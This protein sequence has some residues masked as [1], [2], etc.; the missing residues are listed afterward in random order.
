VS[1]TSAPRGPRK[2]HCVR[3]HPRTKPNLYPNN[4]C[5]LCLLQRGREDRQRPEFQ[6]KR[7]ARRMANI[8][9]ERAKQRE[10]YHAHK[11]TKAQWAREYRARHPELT[12]K[13]CLRRFR[14]TPEEFEKILNAQG[15]ACAICRTTTPSGKYRQWCVDHDHRCCPGRKKS[16][17]KCIRGLLCA[18]CNHALGEAKDNPAILREMANYIERALEQRLGQKV[19]A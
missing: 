14:M 11:A 13:I 7:R 19:A 12:R 2:T 10:S 4:T 18:S 9:V 16:C 6:Q 1:G 8:E 15:R 3:G 5:K 17:G